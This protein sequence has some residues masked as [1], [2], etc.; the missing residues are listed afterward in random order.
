MKTNNYLRK[1]LATLFLM[2]AAASA[3]AYDAYVDGIYY[4][5]NSD[6]K[7][8]EV[9]YGDD[10]YKGDVVIPSSVTCDGVPYDVTSIGQEAFYFCW[11]LTSI[12]IPMSVTSIGDYAFG[13]CQELTS[14]NLPS[15]LMTIG[16]YAFSFCSNI[17]SIIIPSSVTNIGK[18]AFDRCI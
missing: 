5:L 9:T 8:A 6:T 12:S 16:N 1:W 2:L 4:N 18:M 11:N 13:Y 7:Q 15:G 3:N 10:S 14:M 17:N